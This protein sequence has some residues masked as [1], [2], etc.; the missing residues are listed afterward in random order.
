MDALRRYVLDREINF[1][2]Y[3]IVL[4]SESSF[5]SSPAS[6]RLTRSAIAERSLESLSRRVS[7]SMMCWG[8][9]L[10]GPPDDPGGNAQK[11]LWRLLGWS[12]TVYILCCRSGRLV[13]IDRGLISGICCKGFLE[14]WCC[15]VGEIPSSMQSM[16]SAA[17]KFPALSL[18]C[19]ADARSWYSF[20]VLHELFMVVVVGREFLCSLSQGMDAD[21]SVSWRNTCQ[22]MY[23]TTIDGWDQW[24]TNHTRRCGKQLLIDQTE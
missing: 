17:L 10:S 1:S 14:V 11:V 12:A 3:K 15:S 5:P 13:F 6:I 20:L 19:T 24:R 16:R 18:D 7:E 8:I 22:T 9:K 2:P 4:I 23:E 21:G